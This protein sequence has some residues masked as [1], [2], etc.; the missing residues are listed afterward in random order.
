ME[1][2]GASISELS[3]FNVLLAK[4]EHQPREDILGFRHTVRGYKEPK[5]IL[6]EKYGKDYKVHRALIKDIKGLHHIT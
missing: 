2:D 6:Q 4:L 1:V 5:R 3:K